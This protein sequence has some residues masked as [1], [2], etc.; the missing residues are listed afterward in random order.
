MSCIETIE[1]NYIHINNNDL[2][3]TTI[4]HR[5]EINP[6]VQQLEDDFNSALMSKFWKDAFI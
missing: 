3:A 2:V 1:W 4:L 5:T 6:T